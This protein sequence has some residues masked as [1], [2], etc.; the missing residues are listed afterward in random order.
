MN[1]LI[2]YG[3]QFGTTESLAQQMADGLRQHH[4]VRVRHAA[5]TSDITGEGV[6]LLL[7]GAPTQIKGLRLLVRPFLRR[8][9]S[10]GFAGVPAAAFDTRMAGPIEQTGSAAQ[11]IAKRLDS[12][13]CRVVASGESFIA[14]NFQGPLAEGEAERARAWAVNVAQEVAVPV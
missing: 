8:L 3:S 10:A 5:E 14:A 11:A 6:D 7:V 2:V 1:V 13:G 12:A 4:D 9:K